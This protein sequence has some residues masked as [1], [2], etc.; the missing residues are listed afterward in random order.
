MNDPTVSY[1]V[2]NEHTL[3]YINE[4]APNLFGVLAADVNG[5]DG[6]NGP[7]IVTLTDKMRPATAE[8][9]QKFR[10]D[11]TGH[12]PPEEC[13]KIDPYTVDGR[14][15]TR[16]EALQLIW[17]HTHPDYKGKDESGARTILV[18]GGAAGTLAVWL[19]ALSG[20]HVRDK[21]PYCARKDAR[22]KAERATN[23][24]K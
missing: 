24:E 15:Y 21:L 2:L 18:N 11:P 4:R 7:V 23:G 20:E 22:E 8:D 14:T 16:K 17:R 9:F 5:H 1:F 19:D 13:R 12:L 3:G 6:K 10:V